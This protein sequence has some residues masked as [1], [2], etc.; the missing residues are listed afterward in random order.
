MK[1]MLDNL[2]AGKPYDVRAA[3]KGLRKKTE[4]GAVPRVSGEN[5]TEVT[6]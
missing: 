5:M 3:E 6:S 2:M 4:A 1:L